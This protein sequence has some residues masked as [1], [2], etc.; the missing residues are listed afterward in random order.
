MPPAITRIA[1]ER[2]AR[3]PFSVA[4]EYAEEFFRDAERYVD[5]RVPLRDLF[6]ALRGKLHKPV[7]LT[8]A[9]HP[10]EADGGRVHDAVL[11]E[12]HAGTSLFPQFH[13]ALRMRIATID[14]TRLI[15]EGAY[16][17]PL[18]WVGV[19]FDRIAGRRIARATMSDLLGRLVVRMEHREAEFR[20]GLQ[21]DSGIT[22]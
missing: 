7:R 13:G 11:V 20:A 15:L 3:V 8:F 12:W 10:D 21:R 5:V 4:H 16:R 6:W 17:P 2:I 22:A 9:L 1:V 19:V 18:G 14:T